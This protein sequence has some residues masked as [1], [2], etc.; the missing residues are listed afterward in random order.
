MNKNRTIYLD[1]DGVLAD[2]DQAAKIFLN[3]TDQDVENTKK[4]G[5]WSRSQWELIKIQKP[6]FYRSLPKTA[7]ADDLVT[8]CRK[9]RDSLNW[10]LKI[11]TAI[12]KDNDM[13][14][15]FYDKIL[16]QQE[17]YPDIPVMFGPYSKDKF[18][19]CNPN[20]ILI[21]DRLDNCESW[22]KVQGIAIRVN[23][24]YNQILQTLED[25]Y[26]TQNQ[27]QTSA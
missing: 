2:F 26:I 14:W 10:N 18:L 6:R 4:Q 27:I 15:A 12:P 11:L 25:L 13:P 8:I 9:F 1:M 16:W 22:A 5:R 23:N 20:D 17:Y 19:H 7:M 24:N 3:A 21:D